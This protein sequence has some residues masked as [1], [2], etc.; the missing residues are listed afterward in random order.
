[1]LGV[2]SPWTILAALL[3]LL[4]TATGS[5]F[6]GRHVG[7]LE[8]AHAWEARE[9]KLNAD[10]AAAIKA[11]DDKVLAAERTAAAS[12]AAVSSK[13]QAKLKEQENA[14]TRAIGV[15]RLGGL[16]IGTVGTPTCAGPVPPTSAGTTGRDG[17][18]RAELSPDAAEFLIGE[19]SRADKIVEQLNA[20]QA[21]LVQ[22]RK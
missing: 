4:A 14:Y 9:I 8:T 1:M 18:T 17:E 11:A 21:V 5:F 12:T 19:A 2:P 3:I 20:C 6:Y 15:A 7:T 10:S 13:Y 22:D 16:R